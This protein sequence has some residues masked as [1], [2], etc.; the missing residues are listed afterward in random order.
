MSEGGGND[1]GT[2]RQVSNVYF[3]S[4]NCLAQYQKNKKQKKVKQGKLDNL[5]C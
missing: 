2:A 1:S 4:I 5:V 3:C